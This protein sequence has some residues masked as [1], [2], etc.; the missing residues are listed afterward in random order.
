MNIAICDDS[1]EDLRQLSSLIEEYKQLNSPSLKFTCFETASEL[2]DNLQN[3]SYD[4]LILDIVMPDITGINL[5]QKIREWNTQISIIFLTSMPNFALDSYSVHAKDYLLK[6]IDKERLFN[7]LDREALAYKQE[8]KRFL[9]KTNEGVLHVPLREIVSIE[10]SNKKLL[11]TLTD[12]S[13]HL[14]NDYL[15]NLEQQLLRHPAFYKP[16]RSYIINLDHIIHL[17][18]EGFYTTENIL[19]PITKRNYASIKID[20]MNYIMNES[21][22][23]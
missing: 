4:L 17:T 9:I 6:P 3:K 12:K 14:I 23:E 18:K 10:A 19:I 8:E 5:A 15:Y 22:I 13:T 16:H 20:Y 21:V 11:L 7:V 2:F 1:L